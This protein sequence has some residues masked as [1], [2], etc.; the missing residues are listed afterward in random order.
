MAIRFDSYKTRQRKDGTKFK[1]NVVLAKA[2]IISYRRDGKIVREL[3]PPEEL[4]KAAAIDS[5][6]GMPVTD[7]HPAQMI[8]PENYKDYLKGVILTAQ[9][10]DSDKEVLLSGDEAIYDSSLDAAIESGEKREV[11]TGRIVDIDPTPG[12][13]DG[14]RY[15]AI[16]RELRFNHSAHTVSGK[17]G[18]GV[19]ARQRFDSNED[20]LIMDSNDADDP[21]GG[22]AGGKKG[23]G[24]N[25]KTYRSDSGDDISVTEEE[26]NILMAAKKR[27]DS[28]E[29]EPKPV[30]KEPGKGDSN[31][32]GKKEVKTEDSNV[33]LLQ[34][35]LDAQDALI[36]ELKKENGTFENRMDS[37][38]KERSRLERLAGNIIP[39]VRLDSLSNRDIKLA[40]VSEKLPF[41]KEVKIDEIPDVR[42]DAQFEAAVDLART[43]VFQPSKSS[44]VERVDAKTIEDYKNFDYT[45]GD[46]AK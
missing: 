7:E 25:K 17:A 8:S 6:I 9:I 4:K 24:M 3:L 2:G 27:K 30:E 42:V 43:A 20:V 39:D 34:A 21:D 44:A 1:Y 33:A 13:W 35:R 18:P 22:T 19:G 12:I 29:P 32:E 46:D 41:N 5:A 28:G 36:K 14:Q 23:E 37:A 15:D 38:I 26:F 16:Q 40:V 10:E 45:K 11:S 31:S